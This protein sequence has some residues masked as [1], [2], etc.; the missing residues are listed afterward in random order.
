[1]TPNEP[2]AHRQTFDGL[3]VEI[4]KSS[5]LRQNENFSWIPKLSISNGLEK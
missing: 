3:V 4:Y 1:V 5:S 2:H